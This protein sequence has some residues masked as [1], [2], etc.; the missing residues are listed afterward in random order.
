MEKGICPDIFALELNTDRGFRQ[1]GNNGLDVLRRSIRGQG[2]T[3]A[4]NKAPPAM[5][6]DG[7]DRFRCRGGHVRGTAV[8]ENADGIEI[9]PKRDGFRHEPA[10]LANGTR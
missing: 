3:R 9:P 8:S 2:A 1:T 4:E 5:F 7:G 6:A 10:G